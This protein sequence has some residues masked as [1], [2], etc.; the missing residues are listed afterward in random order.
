M[1]KFFGMLM[2]FC[3]LLFAG[4]NS[5]SNKEKDSIPTDSI[6]LVEIQGV[7][8]EK[9]NAMD[10]QYMY[11]NYGADYKWLECCIDLKDYMDDENCTGEVAGVANIFKVV[12]CYYDEDS[13]VT[14]IYPI[15][16]LIAHTQ[17]TSIVEVREGL[18]VGDEPMN[19]FNPMKIS[20]AVAYNRMMQANCPKPHS[21]HCVLRK[22]VGPIDGVAPIYIF[23]NQDAQVY[24]HSTTGD[25]TTQNPCFPKEFETY[26]RDNKR[27]GCPLGEWP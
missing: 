20:Y 19:D 11:T 7:D 8:V 12:T 15:A 27:I 26:G 21:K 5:C 6:E 4:C 24:V 22:E 14:S 2:L 9:V 1:K 18:W 3:C 25:V 17:D 13:N 23:G 16:V 10:M